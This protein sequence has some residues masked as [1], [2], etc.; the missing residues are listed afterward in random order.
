MGNDSNG[1]VVRVHKN[2]NYTVMSN[3]HL[4]DKDLSLKAKG[5]MSLI[6]ALPDDWNYSIGGLT[7]LSNDGRD[8]VSSTLKTLQKFGYV[9][10]EKVREQGQFKSIYHIFE[11]PEENIFTDTD[12]PLRLNR[13]SS[14]ESENP[15]Q[16]NNNNQDTYNQ[17][18]NKQILL[19]ENASVFGPLDLFE[20]YKKECSI[21]PQPMELT[22]KRKQKAQKRLIKKPARE[23]W[24]KVFK[25]ANASDFVKNNSFFSFDWILK[26][27]ENALKVYEG[28]YSNDR[29][30]GNN[31]VSNAPVNFGKYAGYREKQK[32]GVV[33]G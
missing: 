25:N 6:L 10:I 2:K 31:K 20:L 14:A 29:F 32:T 13:C 12:F 16:Q 5:L 18:T 7:T 17:D 26:N 19:I 1:A 3:K 27:D 22:D 4:L 33:N 8:A 23:F 28:N 24:E 30:S 15:Q 9:A 21:F 11:N